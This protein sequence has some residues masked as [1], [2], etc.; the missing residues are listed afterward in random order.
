MESEM[1]SYEMKRVKR[2]LMTVDAVGGVWTYAIELAREYQ[3]KKIEVVLASMGPAPDLFQKEQLKSLHNVELF[4]SRYKL[5]WMEKPWDDVELAGEWLL[6][7][8][9]IT[10]PDVIHLNG[11]ALAVLPWHAPVLVV[12]HSCV[13]SWYENV[14]L[15]VIPDSMG[16][17]KKRVAE[18]LIS[19]E[20]VVAPSK[21]MLQSLFKHYNQIAPSTVIYNGVNL[22]YS[23]DI[24]KETFILTCGRIWDSAK[25]IGAL[26]TVAGDLPWRVFAAGEGTV[27][28]N[29]MENFTMLGKL[30][31]QQLKQ[32]MGKAS[33][34][35]S[36]AKYEPFG[37]SILEAANAGCVLILSDI[38]SL[39]EIWGDAALYVNPDDPMEL[40]NS[41]IECIRMSS[42]RKEFSQRA[43]RKAEEYS[44]DRMAVNYLSVYQA[45]VSK[46]V[47]F[48][49]ESVL[50][51]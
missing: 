36:P 45:M 27:G 8:E 2:V 40:K 13:C 37:L 38:A 10:H 7:L 29:I 50:N 15:T 4:E 16:E 5:E 28:E 35:V 22:K 33:L 39:R 19:A 18:G 34:F 48:E 30:S 3:K 47:N 25:N 31:S 46:K 9:I 42:M 26:A 49:K 23:S 24:V 17:Y 11:Y 41:I 44:S 14:M 32:W 1:S 21:S 43:K 6:E 12:A 20:C 51:K